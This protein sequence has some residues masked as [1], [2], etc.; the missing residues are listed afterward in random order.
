MWWLLLKFRYWSICMFFQYTVNFN[1]PYSFLMEFVSKKARPSYLPPDLQWWTWCL[2]Q[3][4]WCA[5][6]TTPCDPSSTSYLYHPHVTATTCISSDIPQWPSPLGM[7]ARFMEHYS[8]NQAVHPP[9]CPGTSKLIQWFEC[10]IKETIHISVQKPII[11]C[12]RGW[13]QLL[14][15]RLNTPH[16]TSTSEQ[17]CRWWSK[18]HVSELYCGFHRYVNEK[19]LFNENITE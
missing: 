14:L 16:N 11:N 7:K 3:C 4:C 17:G 12:D 10:G 13:H 6:C 2:N 9:R 8:S 19:L 1:K 15:L 18:I 5:L